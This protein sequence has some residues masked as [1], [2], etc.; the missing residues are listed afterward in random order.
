MLYHLIHVNYA[1]VLIIIFLITFLLSNS[2]FNKKINNLF[3][4]AILSV[5]VLII[6][7]SIE[8]WTE[9]LS[10][11]TTL[12][13]LM[14]AI[15][16]T[17]RPLCILNIILITMRGM[18]IKYWL[19]YIPA[20]INAIISFS[21]LFTDIAFSYSDDNKF[22]RGPL[23]ISAYVVCI[24]YLLLLLASSIYYLKER[25][26]YE[27]IIIFIINFMAVISICF[28]VIPKLDGLINSTYAVSITFYYLFFH[29]QIT[30]R[31]VLTQA[32][33]R[34]CF[35]DDA[36]RD[37][38]R[39][40]GLISFDLNN[41]KVLN[42]TMGH[43]AGDEA[44]TAIARIVRRNIPLGCTLYRT[45]G[46]EF[47]VICLKHDQK[48]LETTIQKLRSEIAKTPYS[49]AFGLAMIKEGESF[50]SLCKRA[51]SLMYEDKIR[52]KGF[53]R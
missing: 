29:T 45:G 19:L 25:H 6:V 5:L 32:F 34:R 18:K 39:I 1:T 15:G 16:Y 47:A 11:P 8:S 9:S 21:A 2:I 44:L 20:I 24:L 52:I 14:S 43:A 22:I 26:I 38:T 27:S 4:F 3:F 36:N 28:E 31:D 23:G 42:D 40:T 51:D 17:F 10:Y 30:K 13:V 53:A 49:C 46:D 48:T 7:D 50:D 12:R 33:N 41:L 37:T 35:Y